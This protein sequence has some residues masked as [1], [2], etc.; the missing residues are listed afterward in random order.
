MHSKCFQD[1]I[2]DDK[3]EE[4]EKF[5]NRILNETLD[6]F[7]PLAR[8]KA[9]YL[10]YTKEMETFLKNSTGEIIDKIFEY[11]LKIEG[12]INKDQDL[13]KLV[14]EK[15]DNDFYKVANQHCNE[16]GINFEITK[17]LEEYHNKRL[18]K[19]Y[20]IGEYV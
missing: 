3:V 18:R 9:F 7:Y 8:N 1:R 5:R 16:I 11:T 19:N 12:K 20:F 2:E 14:N 17:M 6:G 4:Y 15:F 10:F 13:W